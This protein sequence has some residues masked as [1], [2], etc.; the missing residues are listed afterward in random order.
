MKENILKAKIKEKYGEIARNGNSESCCSPECCCSSS[1]FD[2]KDSLFAV[3]YDQMELESIP[4]SA[5]LGLGCGAPLNFSNLKE[6]ETVI[7]LGSGAGI[8]VFLASKH[9]GNKGKVIGI[10]FTDDMLSRAREAASQYGFT[11]TD[12]RKADI[13]KTIPVENNTVDAVISNCVI[14]LTSDK[15]G[16]F[17]E[18]YRILKKEGKGRMI[19]SDLVTTKEV[20]LDQ[21]N[22]EKWSGCI[23]GALTRENYIKAIEQAGFDDIKVLNEQVYLQEYKNDGRTIVSLVI[24]AVTRK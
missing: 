15:V 22:I 14:N 16:T 10:D 5:N 9:V 23:D 3:G 4:E 13:E 12:F 8:D 11:N 1:D 21:I 18:I 24:G 2:P 17:K 19:I 20:R 6:G 7:D